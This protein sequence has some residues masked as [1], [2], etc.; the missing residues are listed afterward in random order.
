MSDLSQI[1]VKFAENQD[2]L[3]DQVESSETR[4][5]LNVP[6]QKVKDTVTILG[7]LVSLFAAFLLVAGRLFFAGY[8]GAMNIPLEL[9]NLSVWEYA[10]KVW[11]HLLLYVIIVA[12]GGGIIIALV[13]LVHPFVRWIT[14]KVVN[15][16]SSW[17]KR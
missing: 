12:I 13:I 15:K 17:W 3:T 14:D 10:E 2:V 7:G 1:Q 8:L 9:V 6:S 4:S 5:E 11:R 16:F